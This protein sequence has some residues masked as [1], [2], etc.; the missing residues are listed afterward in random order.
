MT[1][2]EVREGNTITQFDTKKLAK[3]YNST[4]EIFEVEVIPPTK[5][6]KTAADYKEFADIFFLTVSQ[7]CIDDDNSIAINDELAIH[8]ADINDALAKS[9]LDKVYY[10]L[11]NSSLLLPFYTQKRKDK[12][13]RML[14]SFL[15]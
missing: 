1:K 7:D 14:Q 6:P 9:R 15:N 11:L 8:F 12:Y 5:T 3:A 10:L 2:Y 4:A 13:V